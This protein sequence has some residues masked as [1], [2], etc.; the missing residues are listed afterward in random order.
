MATLTLRKTVSVPTEPVEKT[1]RQA[2]SYTRKLFLAGLGFYAK[3]GRA[4]LHYAH[5]LIKAGEGVE[6]RGKQWVRKEGKVL[7]AEVEQA[8]LD[9]VKTE[10]RLEAQVSRLEDAFDARVAGALNRIGIPARRDMDALSAKLD[11]LKALVE[12]AARKG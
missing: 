5:E 7:E 10:G 12:L 6:K 2:R 4:G 1:A 11:E 8:K 9:V 3:L